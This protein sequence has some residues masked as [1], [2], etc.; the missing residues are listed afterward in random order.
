MS[1]PGKPLWAEHFASRLAGGSS[2]GEP[3]RLRVFF[4]KIPLDNLQGEAYIVI[5]FQ[6]TVGSPSTEARPLGQSEEEQHFLK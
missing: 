1:R 2:L 3:L 6:E 4:L 5:V